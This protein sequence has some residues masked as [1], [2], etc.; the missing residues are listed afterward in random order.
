MRMVYINNREH[1]N[2]HELS[3]ENLEG[4][5]NTIYTDYAHAY[6][7]PKLPEEIEK[8]KYMYQHFQDHAMIFETNPQVTMEQIDDTL[9]PKIN[10]AIEYGLF[11]NVIDSYYLNSQIRM[12]LQALRLATYMIPQP[13]H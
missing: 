11:E 8:L 12:I 6:I 13:V 3:K 10:S 7:P 9:Y 5:L 4:S 1:D 2:P